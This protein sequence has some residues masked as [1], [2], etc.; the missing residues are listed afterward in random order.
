A[1]TDI[2]TLTHF[3]KEAIDTSIKMIPSDEE[4][5]T[6]SDSFKVLSD[7]S[8]LKIVFALMNTELCVCDICHV[9]GMSQS[10]ISHQ[11]RVLRSAN[12]VKYKK[13][14]KLVYYSIDDAHVSNIIKISLEHMKH[15]NQH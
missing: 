14:G 10:A 9:V 8:R 3:H 4:I 2:C 5:I 15:T 12:M 7:M 11:L 1:P 6:L 13:K